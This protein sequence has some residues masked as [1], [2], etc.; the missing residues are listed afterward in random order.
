MSEGLKNLAQISKLVKAVAKPH[1]SLLR[2]IFTTPHIAHYVR[3]AKV[4]S[5]GGI[6]SVVEYTEQEIEWLCNIAAESK[7]LVSDLDATVVRSL[8]NDIK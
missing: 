4:N 6:R 5:T 2:D 3:E 8:R 7:Y 1:Y